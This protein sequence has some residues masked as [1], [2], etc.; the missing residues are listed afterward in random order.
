MSK[1]VDG[2]AV[3][4]VDVPSPAALEFH[5]GSLYATIDAL[6]APDSPPDAPPD[7]KVVRIR[8]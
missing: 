6:P 3:E 4:L 2:K 1:L 7:G 5:R 8:L